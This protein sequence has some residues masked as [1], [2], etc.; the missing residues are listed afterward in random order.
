MDISGGWNAGRPKSSH[1]ADFNIALDLGQAG[2]EDR[3]S[4]EKEKPAE[5][6]RA[7][8][9]RLIGFTTGHLAHLL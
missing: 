7:L 3:A 2:D 8:A 5:D 4:G 6:V 9:A 1:G